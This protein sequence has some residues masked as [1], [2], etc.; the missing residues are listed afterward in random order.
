[1]LRP[2]G[3]ASAAVWGER[4]HCAWADVF[5]IVDAQVQSGF[6]PPF[7][8]FGTGD[9]LRQSFAAAGFRDVIV[10]W[11]STELRFRDD[12]ACDAAFI[13]GPVALAYDRMPEDV[14]V[15]VRAQYL[16]SI[17]VSASTDAGRVHQK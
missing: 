6:C 7:F 5:Q 8:R 4:R 13:G 3:R 17:T 16:A 1:M 11:L 9:A 10:K 12:E 14:R 2:G 15:E